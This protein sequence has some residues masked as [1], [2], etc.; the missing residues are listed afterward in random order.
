MELSR[1]STGVSSKDGGHAGA[2]GS[3]GGGEGGGGEGGGGEG[4][5]DGGTL[6]TGHTEACVPPVVWLLKFTSLLV[7]QHPL[8]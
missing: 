4:G 7:L 3:A 2:G 8:G 1:A 6:Q 5:G